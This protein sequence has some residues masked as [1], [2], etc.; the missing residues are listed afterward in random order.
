MF[1]INPQ[2]KVFPPPEENL[3]NIVLIPPEERTTRD[4]QLVFHFFKDHEILKD[5]ERTKSLNARIKCIAHL[6]LVE[7]ADFNPT[8]HLAVHHCQDGRAIVLPL[9]VKKAAEEFNEK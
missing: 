2:E 5:I 1:Y 3:L 9:S 7:Q 4:H 8:E 6:I